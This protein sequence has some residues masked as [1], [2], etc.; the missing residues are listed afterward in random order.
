MSAGLSGE[1]VDHTNDYDNDIWTRGLRRV[2]IEHV[3]PAY[4]S[5]CLQVLI[6]ISRSTQHPALIISPG[7]GI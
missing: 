4:I 2:Y 1:D 3:S 5:I 7:H 6:F